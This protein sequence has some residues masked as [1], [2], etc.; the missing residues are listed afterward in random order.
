MCSKDLHWLGTTRPGCLRRRRELRLLV[1]EL[2]L[3]QRVSFVCANA[4]IGMVELR[5][6]STG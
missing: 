6:G 4:R 5:Y 1:L 2:I 3:K